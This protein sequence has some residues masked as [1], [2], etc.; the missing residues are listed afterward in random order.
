ML[1]HMVVLSL[2]VRQ[3]SIVILVRF[4]QFG[5]RAGQ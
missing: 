4:K 1:E 3:T 2:F 5:L